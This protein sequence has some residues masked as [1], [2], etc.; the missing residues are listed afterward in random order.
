MKWRHKTMTRG[1]GAPD[2]TIVTIWEPAVI[3]E[4][5]TTATWR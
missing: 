3:D 4:I 5:N 2:G 1:A